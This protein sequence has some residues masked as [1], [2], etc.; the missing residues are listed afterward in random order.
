M[1]NKYLSREFVCWK[2][3]SDKLRVTVSAITGYMYIEGLR[4]LEKA[5]I[6]FTEDMAKRMRKMLKRCYKT[7][8][9]VKRRYFN[10]NY[11]S[12][13]TVYVCRDEDTVKVVIK[14]A[15]GDWCIPVYLTD[16]DAKVLRK[17]IKLAIGAMNN[18]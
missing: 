9:D 12:A 5:Q 6:Q 2:T 18:E 8:E 7:K 17:T 15:H 13:D 16:E 11:N 4:P 1:A 10:C 14:P 3:S